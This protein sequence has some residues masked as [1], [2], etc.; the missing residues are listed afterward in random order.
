MDI[1]VVDIATQYCGVGAEQEAKPGEF[2]TPNDIIIATGTHYVVVL[3]EEG[4]YTVFFDEADA[5]TEAISALA[6]FLRCQLQQAE[7]LLD[8][9]E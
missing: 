9:T 3:D 8:K 7:A 4:T 2:I 6:D 5:E 1:K